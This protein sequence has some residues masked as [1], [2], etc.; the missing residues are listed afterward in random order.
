MDTKYIH[1]IHPHSPFPCSVICLM[2]TDI[3]Q[4]NQNF[5]KKG[6]CIKERNIEVTVWCNIRTDATRNYILHYMINCQMSH[7]KSLLE[8]IKINYQIND[9]CN[10]CYWSLV[11]VES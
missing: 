9:I 10:C 8:Q 5:L 3:W 7:I 6:N 4:G 11:G 2:A 1:Q